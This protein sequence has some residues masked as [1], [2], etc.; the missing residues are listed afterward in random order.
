MQ[1]KF[2][3]DR[4]EMYATL[5]SHI[6]Q[7]DNFIITTHKSCD[8]DGMGSELGLDFLLEKLNKKHTILNPDKTPDR[9]MFLDPI[10]RIHSYENRILQSTQRESFLIMVDNSD[11]GRILDISN[12]LNEQKTNIIAIDHHDKVSPFLG[13]YCFPEIGSSSEIIYELIEL[14]GFEPDYNT[15]VALY[16]GIVMDTGQFKYNKTRP[17]TH[18]IAGKLLKHKFPTE[19]LVRKIFEDYSYTVLLLKKDIYSTLDLYPESKLAT[20]DVTKTMLSKYNFTTNPAE[21]MISELL[22]PAD[23]QIAASF[24]ELDNEAVKISLRSKGKYDVCSVAKEYN[25]G[26]HKNASGATIKGEYKK[27]KIDVIEKL[28][29]LS[30]TTH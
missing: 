1:D 9:Y 13:L 7:N 20:I 8:P 21:G 30:K 23:I 22:A 4:T 10:N 19:E 12:Y 2:Q 28:M 11:I 14:A 26:G 27:I 16:M 18:E 24:S 17:R 5:L 29:E 15:A 6:K 25:G 3:I